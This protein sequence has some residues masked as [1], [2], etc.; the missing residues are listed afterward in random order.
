MTFAPFNFP[1][2]AQRKIYQ[3]IKQ[4]YTAQL[5]VSVIINFFNAKFDERLANTRRSSP[6]QVC[7][8]RQKDLQT[9]KLFTAT[10]SMY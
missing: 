1:L 7:V 8:I 3:E 9:H 10:T 4:F 5:F 6:S 2:P